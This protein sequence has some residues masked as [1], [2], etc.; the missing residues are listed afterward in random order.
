MQTAPHLPILIRKSLENGLSFFFICRRLKKLCDFPQIFILQFGTDQNFLGPDFEWQQ[1][2]LLLLCCQEAKLCESNAR[3][4]I[5][6]TS[7]WL[8]L[9]LNAS[10]YT[11]R[12]LFHRV[13]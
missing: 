10:N 7:S 11:E 9:F 8:V 5:F 13:N 4:K 3:E 2:L 6:Q 12:N 1:Q